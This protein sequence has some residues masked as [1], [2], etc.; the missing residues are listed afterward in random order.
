MILRSVY[1]GA[2]RRA[3]TLFG[4]AL[5]TMLSSVPEARADEAV[6]ED[7]A[8]EDGAAE[9]RA[10]T[11]DI[12]AYTA[13]GFGAAGF[14]ASIAAGIYA[15][16]RRLAL[17]QVC[18]PHNNCPV[19]AGPFIDEMNQAATASTIAGVAGLVAMATGT[20]LILIPEDD[21]SDANA[22][23]AT[24]ISPVIGAGSVGVLVSF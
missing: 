23:T 22:D 3:H 17:E 21:T 7:S 6:A 9:D 1:A 24:W 16:D 10:S 4:A 20:V 2:M 5:L 18:Q 15:L 8:A 14:A 19:V 11:L 13:F 12:A